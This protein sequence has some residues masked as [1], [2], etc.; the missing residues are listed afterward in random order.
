MA[1]DRALGRRARRAFGEAGLAPLGADVGSDVGPLSVLRERRADL[2][3]LRLGND[4]PRGGVPGG[5]SR[6]PRHGAAG[7][8]D[9]ADSLDALPGHV[10]R[11]PDQAARRPVLEGPDVPLLPLRDA[12]DAEP[13]LVVLPRAAAV[14]TPVRR[15]VQ[16]LRRA[17]RPVRVFRAAARCRR[18][19]SDHDL[20]PP[21]ADGERQLLVSGI[22]DDRPRDGDPGR[23]DPS[24]ADSGVAPRD[25]S[26]AA[27]PPSRGR[28]GHRPRRRSE[29][30]PPREPAV[31]ASGD[32]RLL[33]SPPPRQH[34]R[35][36]RF[37]HAAEVRSRR[38]GD[39]RR[40][41]R[42]RNGVARVRVQGKA[43]RSEPAAAPDRPVPPEARLAH[44][45]LRV[46]PLVPPAVVR[47]IS[48]RSCCRT[49]R[50]RCR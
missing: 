7:P 23:S 27:C 38:G 43:R 25:V 17:R 12:A 9:P 34:L 35:C 45:V 49:T 21:L 14:G 11:R 50:R 40:R 20:L 37:G 31:S 33:R 46:Q 8:G 39:V 42:R 2:L 44:V 18:R 26:A 19:R 4:A 5:V 24:P 3:R 28:G 10:R 47:R 36:V 22:A 48:S 41:D 1:G 13:V 15:A 32:E 29:H 30:S 6:R 16:P